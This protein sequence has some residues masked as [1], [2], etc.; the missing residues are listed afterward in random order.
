MA[1]KV[2]ALGKRS[3]TSGPGAYKRRFPCPGL[4][5]AGHSEYRRRLEGS[6]DGENVGLAVRGE[7]E[8]ERGRQ[9]V[10]NARHHL[11]SDRNIH[12]PTG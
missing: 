6:V 10:G 4:T 11:S 1:L 2:L 9:K 8:G 12:F 3:S 7:I 5:Q